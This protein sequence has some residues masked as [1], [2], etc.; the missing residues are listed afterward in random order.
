MGPQEADSFRDRRAA[1]VHIPFCSAVCPYCDFAVVAGRDDL[2]GRYIEAL[3]A[4]IGMSAPLGELAAVYFGGGTPSHVSPDLL[5]RALVELGHKHGLDSSAEV[6]AEINPE[7]FSVE[8]GIALK[9]L[10]FNR[11]SFGAQSLDNRILASLGRRHQAEQVLAAVASARD[12]G[13]ENVSIDLIFGTPGESER[14][15][16]RTLESTVEL[17][18]DHVSC[19]ALTVEPGTPLGRAVGAGAAAPD[20]DLQADYYERAD[21]T[22]T[23]AGYQRYEVS[24]WS[25][26]GRECHYNLVVWAQG[27]YEAYGNGAHRFVDGRRE[28]NIRHLDT[29]VETVESGRRPVAGGELV[30]GW[31]AEIDRLF[32]GLRRTVGAVAGRGGKAMLAS[33]HGRLLAELGVLEAR[34]GR[35]RVAKPLLTD[36]VH[37]AVLSLAPPENHTGT[38]NV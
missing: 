13:F 29:Y 31:E 26:S 37:R 38:D 32:V 20:S 9:G 3:I 25:R 21:A 1:Y 2:T 14:S 15:W 11:L 18:V 5:G 23:A 30:A 24:N 35:L 12:A 6:S 33:D 4:E 7:D 27:S 16:S 22:L 8:L 36:E 34:S 28:R 10:G 19:Y 17:G